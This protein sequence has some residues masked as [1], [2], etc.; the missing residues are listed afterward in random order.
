M[1]IKSIAKRGMDSADSGEG[2]MAAVVITAVFSAC[3]KGGEFFNHLK[4]Y[5]I[6]TLGYAQPR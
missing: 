4:E 1:N 5:I 2:T 3:M 6:F